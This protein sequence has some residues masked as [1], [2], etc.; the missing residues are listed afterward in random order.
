MTFGR[1]LQQLDDKSR[2]VFDS[3]YIVPESLAEKA[4]YVSL[5]LLPSLIRFLLIHGSDVPFSNRSLRNPGWRT[6]AAVLHPGKDNGR[7]FHDQIILY[8]FDPFNA[9][10][11]FTCFIDGLLRI[12]EAAQLDRAL[13]RLDT[14]LE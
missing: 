2:F 1:N 3:L 12:N 11:D 6:V 9:P 13:E 10:C 7:L 14:D 8:G 4:L 5:K